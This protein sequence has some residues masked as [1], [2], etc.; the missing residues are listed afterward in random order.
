MYMI[1]IIIISINTSV[2]ICTH[3]NGLALTERSESEFDKQNEESELS[4]SEV[5]DFNETSFKE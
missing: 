3:D 2:V 5:S 1:V 4:S